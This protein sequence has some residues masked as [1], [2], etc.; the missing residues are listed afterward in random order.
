MSSA[1]HIH[2]GGAGVMIGDMLWQLYE[3][4]Y[5]ETNQKN[6]I[7]NE[8]DGN[9][10]PLAL[11]VDTDDRMIHEVQR[12]KSVKFK[13]HSFLHG[14]EDALTYAR[15]CYD[16]GRL[17]Q[18]EAL[19]CIRKQIETMDRLDEFVITSSISGGTGSG[20]CTRLVAELNWQGGYREVRKNGFIIFPSSEMS[21]NIIDTY[22]A[23]LSINIMR[24]YL[25]SITIFDNQSMYNVID[26]QLGL[27][28]V[29]YQHLNNLVA[30]IISSYTGLRRFNSED[31]SEFFSNMCP[32]PHL[33]FI[34][35]SYGKLTLMNDYNRKELE[36]KQFI[37]YLT[38]KDQKLYQ[39]PSNPNHILTTLLLRQQ[40]LNPF[41]G[42]LDI[43]HK[44]LDY[45]FG[46]RSDIFQ[47]KS[48]NYQVLPEL[49]EMKQTGTF[50]SNDASIVSRLQAL[51]DKFYKFK[52]RQA[53]TDT[54][55]KEG[56]EN[57][58]FSE[59]EERLSSLIIDYDEFRN[60]E[61]YINRDL[62]QD[63]L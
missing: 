44:N 40:Y 1:F 17:I 50:F 27:D 34:I 58:E 32:Y 39:C 25:T 60:F 22:N 41:F 15:G 14:K 61:Q 28:F 20:F 23:V 11:F 63:E 57:R 59:A 2:I 56:M 47:C 24:E 6:Y 19:E 26:H 3:K 18:D 46:Y 38:T 49:A 53:Y 62:K 10:Y 16:G 4:E 37:Q 55:L 35:P 43:I 7:Y 36:S 12:N 48:S 5:N 54:Y 52:K 29:D 33:Q 21:N 51:L 45:F 31:N 9:H 42:K 8:V 30:Q 13:K